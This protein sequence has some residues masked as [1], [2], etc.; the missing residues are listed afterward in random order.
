MLDYKM[1][2]VRRC[3]NKEA[4]Y[5]KRYAKLSLTSLDKYIEELKCKLEKA[6]FNHHEEIILATNHINNAIKRINCYFGNKKK[7]PL[8]K[9]EA[10]LFLKSLQSSV[11]I[12]YSF[13]PKI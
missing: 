12:M 4:G 9:N 2:E 7:L 3:I 10:K 11:E 1:Y 5:N 6:G 13:L 8:Q